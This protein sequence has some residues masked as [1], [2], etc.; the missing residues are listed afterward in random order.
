MSKYGNKLIKHII[1]KDINKINLLECLQIFYSKCNV[2]DL[3]VP[4]YICIMRPIARV[5]ADSIRCG[6]LQH[7]SRKVNFAVVT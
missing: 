1:S 4:H 5:T 2:N 3:D 6:V 7:R